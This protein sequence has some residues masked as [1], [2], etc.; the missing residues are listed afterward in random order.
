MGTTEIRNDHNRIS[1][2]AKI[3]AYWRSLSDIPFSKEIAEAVDAER[4]AREMLG[5]R[6]VTMG[7][8]SPSLFEARYRSINYG[9]KKSRIINVMELACGLS[10]RG[11][12]IVSDGGIY[13]GTDLPEMHA[14]SS[15]IIKALAARS[16]IPTDNLHLQPA[17]VLNKDEMESAAAHFEGRKFAICNEG[18]LPYLDKEE[19]AKM[20][21]NIRGLLPADD[22]CWITMDVSFKALRESIAAFFG[23]DTKKVIQPAMKKISDQTGRDLLANDFADKSEAMKFYSDLGF[24]I[25]EFPMYS[26]DY[27]LSTAS[28][29]HES[30]KER[31]LEILS[32]AKVWI[33]TPK[34]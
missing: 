21:E 29:L 19:K 5:D 24:V 18:L 7:S 23:P 12:E 32:S 25:K 20:A 1:P 17:N 11:L 6:I 16:G 31:F 2:T 28:R 9:L 22:G 13:V 4:T 26:G 14:E 34:S 33:M 3:T 15:P 27:E 8:I 10:T 30:F